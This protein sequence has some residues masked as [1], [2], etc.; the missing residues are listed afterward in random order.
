MTKNIRTAFIL[1]LAVIAL[2]ACKKDG[3]INDG[4]IIKT[5][6][7]NMTTYDYLKTNPK[8]DSLI[9]IIDRAGMKD[10]IN[11][12][13]TFFATTNYGIADYVRAKKQER[14]AEVGDENIFFNIDNLD[15]DELKDSLK[16]YMFQ[17]KITRNQL[18]TEGRLFNSMLGPINGITWLIKLRRTYDYSDYLDYVDYVNF[19]KVIGTR[20][21]LLANP[22]AVPQ[23]RRDISLDCQTSGI[24]TTN[25]IL[26]VL[27][28]NHR[29][30][31]NAGSLGN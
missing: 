6:R 28:D 18:T 17:G 21:D 16:N 12:D 11:G 26:H 27:T 31:F 19:T 29:L 22:G 30:F 10:E 8:F 15:P 9:R 23:D 4:G 13:I 24:I 3:Y 14:I 20:D 5:G 2:G 1:L 7:V 25:G